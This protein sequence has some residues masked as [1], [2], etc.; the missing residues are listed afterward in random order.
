MLPVLVLLVDD[1]PEILKVY[2]A[3]LKR[4]SSDVRVEEHASAE[5]ALARESAEA[6]DAVITDQRM[7]GLSGV[8]LLVEVARRWPHARRILVTGFADYV[9]VGDALNAG[10]VH[11]ILA[12]PVQLRELLDLVRRLASE[13]SLRAK[14][15]LLV[16]LEV[17]SLARVLALG[18]FPP[19]RRPLI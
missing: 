1:E 18:R 16:P 7:A 11:G 19:T 17:V 14:T 9:L 15:A 13:E 6:P 10:H 12:K 2:A 4:S 8:D 5:S 3:A